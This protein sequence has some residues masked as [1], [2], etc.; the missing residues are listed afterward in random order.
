MLQSRVQSFFHKRRPAKM[1]E[2]ALLIGLA[3]APPAWSLELVFKRATELEPAVKLAVRNHAVEIC[4]VLRGARLFERETLAQRLKVDQ[5]IFDYFYR[6]SFTPS[7]ALARARQSSLG[8]EVMIVWE[9]IQIHNPGDP[10]QGVA[11]VEVILPGGQRCQAA[12]PVGF[13]RSPRR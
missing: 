8:T 9:H 4:P 10:G 12:G 11:V 1:I 3:V 13:R 5:G 7:P 6:S 2:M